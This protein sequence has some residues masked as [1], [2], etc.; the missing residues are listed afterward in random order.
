[1]HHSLHHLGGGH[2]CAC[3]SGGYDTLGRALPNET[4][5]DTDR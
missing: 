4:G 5:S 2:H 3:V 1:V